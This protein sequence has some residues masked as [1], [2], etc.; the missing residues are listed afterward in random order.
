MS[1][2][3]KAFSSGHG[4]LPLHIQVL[5][6]DPKAF[7]PGLSTVARTFYQVQAERHRADYDLSYRLTRK[8]TNAVV[9]RVQWAFVEW[10]TVRETEA[11]RIYLVALLMWERWRT[12]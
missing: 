8:E 4:G 1:R 5:L 9:S 12:R 3:S 6:A 10:R 7:P 11:A 2:A